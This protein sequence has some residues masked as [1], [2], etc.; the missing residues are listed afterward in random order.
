VGLACTVAPLTA[1]VL[2]DAVEHNAGIAS[3][4]NNA[5]ARV[6]SLMC[7]AALGAVV[8][9]QFN[10]SLDARLHGPQTPAVQEARRATLARVPGVPAVEQASVEAFHL[11]AGISAA[12]VALGGVLGLVGIR[13]PRR[14]VKCADCAEGAQGVS[15]PP[16]GRRE[17]TARH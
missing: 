11:G 10:A 8:A 16:L 14:D 7:V 13:N 1:T 4:V 17:A 12:M 6:A 2:S 3:A 9:A 5:I 15:A